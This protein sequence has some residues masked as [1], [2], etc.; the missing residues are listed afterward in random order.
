M[1]NVKRKY[2]K[3]KIKKRKLVN[4]FHNQQMYDGCESEST[5]AATIFLRKSAET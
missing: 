1:H 2:K 4:E 5:T 3:L